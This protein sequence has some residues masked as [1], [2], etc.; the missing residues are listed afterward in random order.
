VNS[1][2]NPAS[3]SRRLGSSRNLRTLTLT[4][5]VIAFVAFAVG[6]W[7]SARLIYDGGFERAEV[8][9]GLA[10]A[11]HAQALVGFP[12]EYLRRTTIDNAMW[13]EA[14]RYMQGRNPRHPDNL[15]SMTDS[16]RL[17]H[18]SAYGFVGL[19]GHVVYAR[20]FDASREH[21]VPARPEILQALERGSTIGRHYRSDQDSAGFTRIGNHNYSW[22]SAPVLRSDGTGPSAGWWVLL[23]E[24]DGAF[25]ESTSQA[26]GSSATLAVRPIAAGESLAVHIP[27]DA[28]DV[29]I[30]TSDSSNLDIRFPLGKMDETN[31][32]ELVISNPRVVHETAL[33]AS[34]YLLLTSLLFGTLLSTLA[35]RF[36]ERRLL[37]PVHA[38]SRELVRIGQ[39]GDLSLRLAP[40]PAEDEIGRLVSATNDMLAEL[41]RRHDVEIA[42]LGAIP[43]TLLRIDIGGTVLDAR[44]PDEASN[45]RHWPI[46]GESFAK[47]YPA[48]AARR[49]NDALRRAHETGISQHVEYFLDVDQGSPS[50]FEARITRI[51]AGEALVLLRD[52]SERKE[53]EK[54][55][56][57]LAYFDSLTDLPNRSAFLDRLA[58][59]VRRA[60]R[61]GQQFGL[62]FLDL[63]G[64]KNVN[65]TMGHISGDKVLVQTAERLREVLRPADAVSGG[66]TD[67]ERSLSRLGGDEFTLLITDVGGP[68]DV[69]AVAQRI[70][71]AMRRPFEV[72]GRSVTLTSSIGVAVY[73]TDGADAQTLL[74]HAD[75]AMYYAKGLGRDN[76]QLY[77]ASFTQQAIDR[78]DLDNGLRGAIARDEFHLVYQPV[79]DL[80][81]GR[82][83]SVEAL[84]RWQHPVRGQIMPATFIP[85]AEENGVISAIGKWVLQK[86]CAD[87][88][89]WQRAG[90]GLR[91]AVNVSPRQFGGPDLV[92][93][94]LETLRGN[95]LTPDLLELEITEGAVIDNYVATLAA[96]HAFREH[97]V[98]IALDDFGTGYS[99]LSYL[100]QIPIDILKVDRSFVGRLVEGGRSASIIEA[101]LAL[102]RALGLTVIAE[103]VETQEQALTLKA[104]SC[105]NAQGN[106]FGAPVSAERIAQ[107]ASGEWRIAEALAEVQGQD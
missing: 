44:I 49:L 26:L 63:D 34:Q 107:L 20:Q 48:D 50:H 84:V 90:L 25:L 16:F 32:L 5:L 98:R 96:L 76:S 6:Q 71:V 58:R 95:G 94:V 14:Y 69:L 46:P 1:P 10:Q 55:V 13:D 24:L 56:A 21:L 45:G 97:G 2:S 38:A 75:S 15:L 33:R 73:P 68:Q 35:I 3:W 52:I 64:F 59:E 82:M 19:D 31:A 11:R 88:A 92:P 51:N 99:S 62:L 17:L 67:A 103:G 42:M 8:R 4:V 39:S 78:L 89:K 53:V 18:M 54:R 40:A 86:A 30:S 66:T 7:I 105:Q 87:L 22:C 91:V 102:S 29:R 77:S 104:M 81:S 47:N 80:V 41:Q 74:Q 65:D 93:L 43:D 37:R 79:V 9:E 60:S 101:I 72:D 57:R 100:R 12:I 83:I 61:S 85:I 23:S 28:G 106:Y 36:V 70:I 27:L